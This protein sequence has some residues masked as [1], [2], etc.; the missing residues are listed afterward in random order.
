MS[1]QMRFPPSSA[2]VLTLLV[3]QSHQIL[4][5]CVQSRAGPR[6]TT[7]R[8]T[9]GSA[10]VTLPERCPTS[11]CIHG[12]SEHAAESAPARFQV[13]LDLPPLTPPKPHV[14][15]VSREQLKPVVF[16]FVWAYLRRYK[17]T[18]KDLVLDLFNQTG[19]QPLRRAA[20]FKDETA[21]ESLVEF[22][23]S[24]DCARFK[25][26]EL[27]AGRNDSALRFLIN[28]FGSTINKF[29]VLCRDHT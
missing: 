19:S 10:R 5:R 24:C 18:P 21:L 4:R 22:L 3:S 15:D 12:S 28:A 8:T 25:T 16:G 27:V 13:F 11:T 23:R 26:L 6:S 17:L 7:R 1:R 2:V 14:R 9:K 20:F 29:Y